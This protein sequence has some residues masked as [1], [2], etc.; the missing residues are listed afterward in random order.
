MIKK[1]KIFF[2][3]F[4]LLS[5]NFSFGQNW[6]WAFSDGNTKNDEARSISIDLGGNVFVAVFL[7]IPYLAATVNC[8][9]M[10]LMIFSLLNL[11]TRATF[12]GQ[13]ALAELRMMV[14]GFV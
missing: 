1:Y 2:L 11:I 8:I 9:V 14:M 7:E 3:L 13:D 5:T 12:Y 6:I 4:S 10:V